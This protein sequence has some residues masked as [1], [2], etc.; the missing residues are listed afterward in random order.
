M[1]P[2]P[3][4]SVS[5]PPLTVSAECGTSR[6]PVG[7]PRSEGLE[8]GRSAPRS[9]WGNGILTHHQLPWVHTMRPPHCWRAGTPTAR[10]LLDGVDGLVNEA[11]VSTRLLG[12]MA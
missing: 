5:H 12:H 7:N 4:S 1:S 8:P 10:V 3:L 6:S 9:L 11:S 2:H